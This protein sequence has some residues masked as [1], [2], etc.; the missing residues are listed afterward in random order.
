[1]LPPM[2]DFNSM[3]KKYTFYPNK[4]DVGEETTIKTIV[5]NDE[6]F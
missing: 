1:M 2:I 6:D 3:D 4:K 5:Q